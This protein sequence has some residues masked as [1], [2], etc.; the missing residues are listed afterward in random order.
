MKIFKSNTGEGTLV[1]KKLIAI[2]TASFA[3]TKLLSIVIFVW[4]QQFLLKNISSSEYAIYAVIS[5]LV[6]FMP[7]ISATF[8]K[9][10]SRY[11]TEAYVKKQFDKI[12]S[13]ASTA[14]IVQAAVSLLILLIAFP[15]IIYL[16]RILT[17]DKA[18]L[19]ESQLMFAIIIITFVLSFIL[20]PL[21]VGL[22]VT[23][24]YVIKNGID[25]ICEIIKNALLFFLLFAVSTKAIWLVVANSVGVILALF[26]RIIISKKLIS[27][28]RFSHKYYDKTFTNKILSFGSWSGVILLARYLR[29]FS[30]LF[31][32]NKLGNNIDVANFNIGRIVSRQSLQLFEP[33]RSSLG[34]P[35]TNL[36]ALGQLERLKNSYIKGARLATWIT[37]L[38]VFPFLAFSTEFVVLYAGNAYL[39]AA[40]VIVLLMSALPFQMINIL[41]PQ[42]AAAMDNQKGLA[43]RLITIQILNVIVMFVSLYNFDVGLVNMILIS[44]IVNILGDMLV[45]ATF[46]TKLLGVNYLEI[47]TNGFLIGVLPGIIVL[48]LWLSTK[49]YFDLTSYFDLMIIII[50]GIIIYFVLIYLFSRKEDKHDIKKVL[51][52]LKLNRIIRK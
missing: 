42:I 22:H 44:I 19:L 37:G 16:D 50:P 26:L 17:I 49:S 23:Q 12:T 35:L 10:S 47:L 36:F 25:L 18:F 4:V 41:L 7:F 14:V 46:S 29:N 51:T 43:I 40:I 28:M 52:I 48:F 1:S 38:A 24:S 5:S 34:T 2:N 30:A 13:I 33:L 11:I 45:V 21:G 27:T 6:F 9:A 8:T 20:A 3:V 31:L 32:L 39:T 15:L